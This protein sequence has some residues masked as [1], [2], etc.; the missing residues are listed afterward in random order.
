MQSYPQLYNRFV[1]SMEYMKICRKRKQQ[2]NQKHQISDSHPNG[3]KLSKTKN[4]NYYK[5]NSN[6]VEKTQP[7]GLLH[8]PVSLKDQTYQYL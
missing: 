1:T 2:Q 5:C 4:I 3:T 7:Y 6:T 8:I